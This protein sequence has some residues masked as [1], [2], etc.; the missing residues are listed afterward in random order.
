MVA[1]MATPPGTTVLGP[2]AD[3]AGAVLL[4]SSAV[5]V[6]SP[7]SDSR[8]ATS[9]QIWSSLIWRRISGMMGSKPATT[10]LSGTVS[11]S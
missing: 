11:D 8:K 5:T 9:A 4:M 10:N 1:V 3:G 2:P 7:P 6:T